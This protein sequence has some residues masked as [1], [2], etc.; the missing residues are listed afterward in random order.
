MPTTPP[1][2]L[3]L[4]PSATDWVCALGRAD[5]LVGV[6]HECT[7]P[8][9]VSRPPTVVRPRLAHDPADPA[10]VDRAVTAAARSGRALYEL[11]SD[12]VRAL[13]PTVVLTQRLCDVC[14]VD[15]SAVTRLAA[16]LGA[17]VVTLDGV[18]LDGVVHD[19]LAVGAAL[20]ADDAAEELVARLRARL[21]RVADAVAGRPH[22]AVGFVEWPDPLW[23]AGHWVPDQITVAGGACVTD[24]A[25]E[26]SRRGELAQLDGADVVVVGP[27]GYDLDEAARAAAGLEP[28]L[29]G[30][31]ALWAVDAARAFSRPGPGLVDGVEAL[32][33]IFHPHVA[34][35]PDDRLARLVHDEHVPSA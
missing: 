2:V 10:G 24:G 13:A 8:E 9:G 15:E 5:A 14:A 27:C 12:V 28:D 32:A 26:P 20:G 3:S 25:G 6:T 18:R 16:E 17:Q 22:V 21:D 11:R 19:A 23:V 7:V 4:V 33:G 30:R 1:R 31:P 34:G 35:P 29:P